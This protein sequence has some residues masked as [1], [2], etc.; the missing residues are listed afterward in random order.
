MASKPKLL[1]KPRKVEATTDTEWRA[2]HEGVRIYLKNLKAA[3]GTATGLG[4]SDTAEKW[5]VQ[6]EHLEQGLM[7]SLNEQTEAF[8]DGVGPMALQG[9]GT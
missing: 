5:K 7:A 2:I 3:V 1:A 6:A 9:A 4:D 8:G